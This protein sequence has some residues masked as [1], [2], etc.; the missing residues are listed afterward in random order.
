MKCVLLLAVSAAAFGVWGLWAADDFKTGQAARLIIGQPQFTRQDFGASDVLL[1]GASGVAYANNML[2]VAD[3]NRVGASPSNNRVLIYTNLSGQLPRATDELLY[4]DP[5]LS[6]PACSGHRPAALGQ[7]TVVLGQPDFTKTDPALKPTQ[8]GLRNPTA[9]AS[10]GVHLV[11]ADTDSNRVLIWNSIP[12]QNNQPADVVVGQPNFTSNTP[13]NPPNAS[14]MSGPQG[15][16]IG[17]DG[18]LLVADTH[19]NR[20]MIFNRIPTANG[21]AA[22]VVLGQPNFNVGIEK[23]IAQVTPDPKPTTMSDPVSVTTDPAGRLFVADLGYNRVLIWNTI[24]ASNQA[25]ADIALGQPDETSAIANNSSKLCASN[26]TDDQGNPTYPP[27]CEATLSFPRFAL[28]DGRRLFVADGGNDRVLIWSI[29]PTH[30]GQAADYILGQI[31]GQINQASDAA[32]SQRTPIALAWDGVNLYVADSYNRRINVYT[33]AD[34]NIPYTAVRNA[35]SRDIFA[36]GSITLSGTIKEND[37][38]T[39]KI[40]DTSYPALKIAKDDTLTSVINKLVKMLNDA[41][42]GSGDPNVLAVANPD[43]DG[44]ILSARTGGESGNEIAYSV[45][46]STNATITATTGGATLSG[47][48]D[49]AKIGPGTIVRIVG[50]RLS[51][52]TAAADPNADVLPTELAGTQVYFDGVRAP[53]MF[54]SPEAITAQVPVE[55]L[56]TTSINAF[57]RTRHAN[58]T[59]SVSTPVAVTI[60]PQNP[61]IFA[62]EGTDPRPGIVMH[63]SSAATGTVSVDGTAKAGDVAS[64]IIEDRTYSYTVKDGDTLASIR[65]ALIDRI[66]ADPKVMAFPAGVFTRI[67]LKARVEGPDGNGI[68]YSANAPEGSNVIMTATTPALCCANVAGARVTDNNPALPGETIIVYATGLGLALPQADENG[69]VLQ[70]TGVK[71]HGGL[72]GPTEFVSSLAGGKTANVLYAGLA[73]DMVGIWQVDLELNSDIPSNPVTQ[74]TIAQDVYVSNII[75]FPVF[76]PNPPAQ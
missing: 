26:G 27:K 21:A 72:T 14:S 61:G 75:T 66:N 62:E 43:T 15:V 46:T 25:P 55:F 20:V 16:W 29:V 11:V 22:N 42:G 51:E 56:D 64:V 49:A 12:T 9:V 7:A 31:G 19:N 18:K 17:Q 70:N 76:N 32:D 59:V 6:C 13:V 63:G 52:G 67:R 23:N 36:V 48:G 38:I 8:S 35:A 45:T 54:V 74:L 4:A 1:G 40:Q 28:S 69:Q 41:N 44:I 53:L 50:D 30:D 10:D 60:V 2:F 39:I 65:D 73:K 68:P 5:P 58:G 47:G 37:T 3:S 24:P 33:P 34:N 71:F 57:V